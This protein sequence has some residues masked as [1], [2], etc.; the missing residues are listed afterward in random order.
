MALIGEAQIERQTGQ[1]AL[2]IGQTAQRGPQPKLRSVGVNRPARLLSKEAAHVKGRE[3]HAPGQFVNSHRLA[4]SIGKA[5]F[6]PI[7][8][9]AM[10]PMRIESPRANRAAS[11]RCE[12]VKQFLGQAQHR[13]FNRDVLEQTVTNHSQQFPMSK[14]QSGVARDL[15][16]PEPTALVVVNDLAMFGQERSQKV[17]TNVERSAIVSAADGMADSIALVTIEEN[18]VVGIGDDL[19]AAQMLDE[20]TAPDEDEFVV[21]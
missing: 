10:S 17:G 16:R 9:V 15:G 19:A 21:F 8:A 13:L 5:L 4:E 2:A 11:P 3:M 12:I 6:H 20:K 1:V 14:V 7:R 18:D